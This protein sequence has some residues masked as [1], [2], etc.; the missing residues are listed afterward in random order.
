[1]HLT[2]GHLIDVPPLA[3]R[4]ALLVLSVVETMAHLASRGWTVA[5]E[6]PCRWAAGS[7]GG[8]GLQIQRGLFFS[9]RRRIGRLDPAW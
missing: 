4:L 9:V 3:E 1:M 5:S 7:D 8:R 2:L 6:G